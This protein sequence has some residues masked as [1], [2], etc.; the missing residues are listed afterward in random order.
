VAASDRAKIIGEH[1]R[2]EHAIRTILEAAGKKHDR[3]V[4]LEIL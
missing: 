3:H 4:T 2:T 1:G